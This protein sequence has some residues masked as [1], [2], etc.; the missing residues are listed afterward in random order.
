MSL[1]RRSI[2]DRCGVRR[3]DTISV[4]KPPD[5]HK[6]ENT[7]EPS[8]LRIKPRKRGWVPISR[9]LID[10]SRLQFDTRAIVNW[11][12]AKS[13]GWQIRLGALPYL[14]QQRAG[15]GERIGRDRVRRMLR[16]LEN[17]GYLTRA[18]SKKLDG[19]WAWRVELSDTPVPSCR[20][21]TMGGSA[22]DGSAVDGSP[23]D[24]QGV[25]LLN[26]L[27]NSRLDNLIP[28]TTTEPTTTENA[29]AVVP[30][31][32]IQYPDVLK[33]GYVTAARRLIE[34]CPPEQRQVV[35]DEIGAMHARGKVRS[36]LGL[37]RSLVD[38]AKRGEFSP[39]YSLSVRRTSSSKLPSPVHSGQSST[40]TRTASKAPVLVSE[41]AV[42]SFA[43]WREK[44]KADGS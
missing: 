42:R 38:K 23:V 1:A 3:P 2:P 30:V 13:D 31:T 29:A 36:P 10:D 41:G 14:L 24:G 35:L 9:E 5:R 27:N 26:T 16:E 28:T 12:L 11:L 17:A 15:P 34:S 6:I 39:N 18:R 4:T 32:E 22:V 8:V 25:D 40:D 21:S 20:I 44:W 43:E 33:G 19:R 37:L 7:P